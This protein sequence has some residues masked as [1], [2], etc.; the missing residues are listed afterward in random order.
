M[1]DEERRETERNGEK[2]TTH[3]DSGQTNLDHIV[4]KGDTADVCRTN[5]NTGGHLSCVTHGG[6]RYQTDIQ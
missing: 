3:T 4:P 2:S 5:L 6:D 1:E